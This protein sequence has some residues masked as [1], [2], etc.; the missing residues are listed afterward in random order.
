[1]RPG[2]LRYLVEILRREPRAAQSRTAENDWSVFARVRA[3]ILSVS[4]TE[5]AALGGKQATATHTVTCR[6]VDGV[7][8]TMRL[9]LPASGRVFEVSD[10]R[11]DAT[12]RRR[13]TIKATELEVIR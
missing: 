9:R 11:T 4:T 6:Y 3:S 8:N 2:S 7:N 13:L 1:M 12:G 5:R 10:I